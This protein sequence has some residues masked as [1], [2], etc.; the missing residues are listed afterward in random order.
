M[1]R[2]KRNRQFD[3]GVTLY[4]WDGDTLAWESRAADKAGEGARTTHYL[5]EPGSFVPVAQA[6]HKRFIPLIPE[7]EYGAFYQQENDPLWADAPKPMEIDALAWYQCDHLGTPQELTDQTGEVVWSAQYKAWGGIKEERSSSALQQGITNPL[8]FQGQYHDPETGLHYNR[9]R[10]YDPEVGRFISRDPIGYT[11]GLNVFQYAPNPVEWI[12]PLG[13]QKK[14]RVPPHMSQQK[15]AG[16]VLG[17]P[18]YDNRV[19]QGKATSC[20]CDWDDAIQY[21]DEAWDKGVPVPKRP[22]VR[23]HDFKT[24]IGFGPNGGTQTSVR[25]HQ[26]NAGKIHGHPKGPETK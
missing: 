17:E 2:L 13:L 19:K 9:Y 21:T 15:Q 20:F 1:E 5:Y 3:C 18:Q 10:Y 11:G 8:R 4:G 24:P 22:N 14:H 7:P 23:D 16:H 25:V 6:V 26:D 12:D